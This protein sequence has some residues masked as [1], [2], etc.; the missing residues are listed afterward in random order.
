MRLRS[1]LAAV[2]LLALV[3][4]MSCHGAA[5][6]P[7]PKAEKGAGGGVAPA[8]TSEHQ[9][10][11][12]AAVSAS[13]A[14][15]KAKDEAQLAKELDALEMTALGAGPVSGPASASAPAA[16][17]GTSAPVANAGSSGEVKVPSGEIAVG[18]AV[19][20]AKI[21]KLA[22]VIARQRW[23]FKACHAKALA[24]DPSVK[25][26]TTASVTVK[27]DGDVSEANATGDLGKTLTACVI[28][29]FKAMKF[30]APSIG[31][32]V[33]FTVKLVFTLKS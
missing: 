7:D 3:V 2:P 9:E 14:A 32:P 23:R 26:A 5:T 19:G 8:A 25:G 10:K 16:D 27:A 1:A 29:S 13:A 6:G 24:S 31:A 30:E 22:E 12:A 4:A 21:P 17:A 28:S 33:T 15:K 11:A 20:G 18:A